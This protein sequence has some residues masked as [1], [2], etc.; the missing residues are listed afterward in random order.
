M[1][2]KR[3]KGGALDLPRRFFLLA[4]LC[5]VPAVVRKPKTGKPQIRF[6][7]IG[8][9]VYSVNSSTTARNNYIGV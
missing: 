1:K 9:E 7:T 6:F 3:R 2:E 8:S 4:S 5:A